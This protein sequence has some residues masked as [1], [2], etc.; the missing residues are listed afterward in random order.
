MHDVITRECNHCCFFLIPGVVIGFN[1][2]IYDVYED[3]GQAVVIVEL[4]NGILRRP[5][6]VNID[7]ADDTALGKPELII[8]SLY[9]ESRH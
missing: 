7:T 9:Q 3:A 4:R 8:P 5:V 1:Q 6:T 2:P